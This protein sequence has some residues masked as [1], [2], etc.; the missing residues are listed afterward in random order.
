MTVSAFASSTSIIRASVE[1]V[2]VI[3]LPPTSLTSKASALWPATS[4]GEIGSL[5][6]DHGQE[7]DFHPTSIN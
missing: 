1:N 7:L 4:L 5:V 2:P 3:A 6:A